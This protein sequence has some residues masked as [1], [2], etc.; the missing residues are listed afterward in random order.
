MLEDVFNEVYTKFK[1][2]F[3]RNIF[4]RLQERETSLSAS[5]AY[6]VEVIYAL[7]EPTISQFA[8]FLQSSLPNT[9]Y[10]V[11]T[12]VS[13]GYI[14]KVKSSVDKREYHLRTTPKFENYYAINQNYL[15]VVTGRIQERFSDEE[16]KQFESMM[17]IISK[18]LMPESSD[19]L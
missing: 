18:E 10:K 16:I 1:L 8:E 6:A 12:L 9:T 17:S 7:R 11:N 19:K 14:E 2:N 3:Y 5:E 13:K 4:E 15:A